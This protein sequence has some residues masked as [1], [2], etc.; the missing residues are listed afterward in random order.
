MSNLIGTITE[1]EKIAQILKKKNIILIVDAAQGIGYLDIDI[2]KIGIDILC[3]L[4]YK[5]LFGL[6]RTGSIYINSSI[7]LDAMR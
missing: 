6:I 1:I 5:S 3:F 2:N 7:V 4:G